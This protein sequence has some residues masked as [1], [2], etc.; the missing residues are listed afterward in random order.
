MII[1]V[2]L[3]TSQI[4]VI[5]VFLII[6]IYAIKKF[7]MKMNMKLIN[8]HLAKYVI[9]FHVVVAQ[10]ATFIPVNAKVV[11]YVIHTS[12]NAVLNVKLFHANVVLNVILLNVCAAQI[13]K[14]FHVNAAQYAI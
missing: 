13:A 1:V 10:Y 2:I 3:F 9:I 8:I 11:L 7:Q 14:N 5:N 4:H 12:A 6:V